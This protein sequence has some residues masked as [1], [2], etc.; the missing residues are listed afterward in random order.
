VGVKLRRVI[1]TEAKDLA[2]GRATFFPVVCVTGVGLR[3]LSL[4]LRLG[5]AQ[6]N[7]L[8]YSISGTN[9][10]LSCRAKMPVRPE[11]RHLLMI[12]SCHRFSQSAIRETSPRVI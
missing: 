10:S 7:V 6:S 5:M 3:G 9:D 8:I 1:L 12:T 11:P 4:S 2:F